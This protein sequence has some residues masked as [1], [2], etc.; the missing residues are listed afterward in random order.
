MTAPVKAPTR[1]LTAMTDFEQMGG[2]ET[3]NAVITD[4]VNRNF[5]DFI[6][7]YLFEG[8]DKARI[9]RHESAYAAAHLGG[10]KAYQGKPIAST[11]RPL[12]INS[13]HFRRRLAILRTTLR[14]HGVNEDIIARW[15][16]REEKLESVVT[17]GTHCG[18]PTPFGPSSS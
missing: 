18:P 14:D 13:G 2:A 17:D 12:R 6:I 3:V 10:P 4:F 7:G 1:Y 9:I 15:I 11:H 8:R 16:A 5:G